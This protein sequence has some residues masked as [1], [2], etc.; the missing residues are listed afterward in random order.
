MMTNLYSQEV[1]VQHG[2]QTS[3]FIVIEVHPQLG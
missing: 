3:V 2:N 1:E